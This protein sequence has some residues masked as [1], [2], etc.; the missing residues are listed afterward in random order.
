MADLTKDLIKSKETEEPVRLNKFLS[1]AGFCSR[2]EADRLI[3]A[4]KV[5]VDGTVAMMGQKVT[6]G[7][8]VAVNGKEITSNDRLILLAYN[9]PDGVE[10]TTAKDNPDNIVDKINYPERIYPVGRLDKNS[11]GLILLTNAGELVNQILKGSNYHEKEYVVK[12]NHPITEPFVCQMKNGV[13]IELEDGKK[14]VKTRKCQVSPIDEY[15]FSIILTQGLNRQIRRMC[16]ALGYEVTSLKRIR[17][18]N[19]EL[20]NLSPGRY[21]DVTETELMDLLKSLS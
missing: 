11:T 9:K 10:C 5:L 3:E 13:V 4:G 2:R 19:I 1:D 16:K 8:S 18:M 15:T 6:K 20:N 12:V 14:T 17:I 7:Q 21:R